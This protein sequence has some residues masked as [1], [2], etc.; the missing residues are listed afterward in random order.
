MKRDLMDTRD[1]KGFR[2]HLEERSEEIAFRGAGYSTASEDGAEAGLLEDASDF[3]AFVALDFNAAVFDGATDAAGFLHLLGEL[4]FFRKTDANEVGDDGNGFAA[5]AG[6]VA[7][8]V[9]DRKST[10]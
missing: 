8:D 2:R 5:A 1:T 6:G 9:Q 10:R 7:D 3:G 4:F